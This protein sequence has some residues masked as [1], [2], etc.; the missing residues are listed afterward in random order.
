MQR[1]AQAKLPRRR[2][3]RLSEREFATLVPRTPTGKQ[4]R[5]QLAGS[6]ANLAEK[7]G[8]SLLGL[9]LAQP[10]GAA[11]AAPAC[12]YA[13]WRP[14]V[15]AAL[16]NSKARARPYAGIWHSVILNFSIFDPNANGP[17]GPSASNT[18]SEELLSVITVG[19][20]TGVR[21][22][23]RVPYCRSHAQLARSDDAFLTVVSKSAGFESFSALNEMYVPSKDVFVSDY[24][25]VNRL[26][27]NK[28]V[29]ELRDNERADG[30]DA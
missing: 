9:L 20:A 15:D 23:I 22:D 27:F 8:L 21:I 17:D 12:T 7:L 18:V 29:R 13:A 14:V 28:L 30:G 24:P 3:R 6:P 10:L 19:D 26:T 2:I 16:R 1:G 4:Y 11:I 5:S 25:F